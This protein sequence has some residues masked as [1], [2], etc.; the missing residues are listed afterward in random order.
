MSLVGYL[1]TGTSNRAQ[2]T[3]TE[4][5]THGYVFGDAGRSIDKWSYAASA[6]GTD[7]GDLV[8]ES[9]TERAWPTGNQF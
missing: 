5:S 1:T 6:S 8:N 4:S 9:G 3:G 7:V 2:N